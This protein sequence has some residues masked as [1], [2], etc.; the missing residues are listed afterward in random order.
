MKS[1]SDFK[2]H[3]V[4]QLLLEAQ[5]GQIN[6]A[7]VVWKFGRSTDIT[8]S[9]LDVWQ[10]NSEYVFPISASTLS[11]VSTTADTTE[12]TIEGLDADYNT[13]LETINLNG[14]TPVV[15]TNSFIRVNRAYNSNGADLTGNVSISDGANLLAYI[16][17]STNQ[18][19]QAIYTVPAGYTAYLFKGMASTSKGKDAQITFKYRLFG[20]AFRVSET[21]GVFETIYEADRPFLPMPEKT[22]LKV[23]AI[24][25]S[26]GTDVSAQFGL[27]LLKNSTW[28]EN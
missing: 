27:L 24:S 10:H 9:T 8:T 17:S 13:I 2:G 3:A 23:S 19:L 20:K 16:Q 14:I 25:S 26:S 4:E 7:Y 5:M 22:D 21:F 1:L 18:T 15:T 12:I 11:A 6:D 28:K